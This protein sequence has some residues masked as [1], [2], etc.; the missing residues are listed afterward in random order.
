MDYSRCAGRLSSAELLLQE[1]APDSPR[2]GR[3]TPR[4]SRGGSGAA[5]GGGTMTSE[6]RVKRALKRLEEDV[7]YHA[8]LFA[9]P[10]SL[11]TLDGIDAMG[12]PAPA[13][14]VPPPFAAT[15][16]HL[17]SV[18]CRMSCGSSASGCW[19][20]SRGDS[21]PRPCHGGERE[22]TRTSLSLVAPLQ[23]A[24]ACGDHAA[25]NVDRR[26]RSEDQGYAHRCCVKGAPPPP[27]PPRCVHVPGPT[28]HPLSAGTRTHRKG[29]PRCAGA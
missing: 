3:S 5:R 10:V 27:P 19:S 6:E 23:A 12:Q 22:G 25:G 14:L 21:L 9:E 15:E 13:P 20:P 26:L 17:S 16:A 28:Q 8:A 11:R 1:T 7:P 18:G 4:G 29:T 24:S 2:E